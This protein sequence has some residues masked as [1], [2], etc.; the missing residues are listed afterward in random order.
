MMSNDESWCMSMK[1]T[2]G[3]RFETGQKYRNDQ[4]YFAEYE[5][6]MLKPEKQRAIM[7]FS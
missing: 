5:K 4:V 1:M 2:G 6:Y 7:T 3:C